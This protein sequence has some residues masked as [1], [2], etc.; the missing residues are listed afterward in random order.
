MKRSVIMTILLCSFLALVNAQTNQTLE[1]VAIPMFSGS[2]TDT[3][4]VLS[5]LFGTR[6]VNRNVF[7]V[8]TRTNVDSLIAEMNYQMSGYTNEEDAVSLGKQLNAQYVIQGNL[9]TLGTLHVLYVQL[10]DVETAQIISG[11]ETRFTKI[12]DAYDYVDDLVGQMVSRMTG[13]T[14]V[15]T[16]EIKFDRETLQARYRFDKDGQLISRITWISG[17]VVTGLSGM[18]LTE[19]GTRPVDEFMKDPLFAIPAAASMIAL[20]G[21]VGDLIFSFRVG[22]DRREMDSRDI[23]YAIIP[24]FKPTIAGTRPT[25][26]LLVHLSFR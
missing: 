14:F 20:G 19:R 3:A 25:T 16:D 4:R 9:T 24:I 12:E 17:V 7:R 26:G 1:T 11:S 8:L 18:I 13:D 5:D 10:I 22:N 15:S 21:I 6:L 2:D 23:Q